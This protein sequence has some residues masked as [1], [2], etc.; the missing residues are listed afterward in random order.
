VLVRELEE[1]GTRGEYVAAYPP[2]II[3]AALGDVQATRRGLKACIE[4][5]TPP[6][7]IQCSGGPVLDAM[8]GDPEID[9]LLDVL[10]DG[11]HRRPV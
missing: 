5:S 3:Q 8:R 4:D 6:L 7:S 1:R 2:M 11:A 9:R 10:Y